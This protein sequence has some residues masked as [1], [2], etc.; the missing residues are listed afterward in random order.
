VDGAEVVQVDVADVWKPLCRHGPECVAGR[1]QGPRAVPASFEL[2][3]AMNRSRAANPGA[4]LVTAT[5]PR[6]RT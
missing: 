4:A 6:E 1:C 2:S 3:D 5:R